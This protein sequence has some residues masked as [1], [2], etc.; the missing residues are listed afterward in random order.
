[1]L[2][3]NA[4]RAVLRGAGMRLTPQRL[5]IIDA[6]VDNRSHPT[7]DQVYHLVRQQF[8][9]VSLATVYQTISLLGRHGLILELKGGKDGLR[10]DPDTSSHAHAYCQQCGAVYDVPLPQEIKIETQ[11][12]PG[13][14][15]LQVEVSIHGHCAQCEQAPAH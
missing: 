3:M 2:D 10:C 7:V 9:T 1:M 11:G 8:P 4:A 12:L 5:M 13:F 15:P 6:L 14:V